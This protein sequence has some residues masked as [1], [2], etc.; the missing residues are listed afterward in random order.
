[1]NDDINILDILFFPIYLAVG[2]FFGLLWVVM[3]VAGGIKTY[4]EDKML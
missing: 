2:V 4:I 1:M 3:W